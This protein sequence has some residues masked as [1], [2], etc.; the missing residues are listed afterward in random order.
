MNHVIQ[1]LTEHRSYRHYKKDQ[2]SNEQLD[3][4][5]ASAQ[6]APSW[7]HGQQV[8]VIVVQDERKKQRLAEL[9]GN[10][11]Y[12][13]DCP[14]F[15]V[16]CA[17]FYRA[18]LASQIEEIPIEVT[19]DV[20]A[21]LI[22]ATD[23]GIALGNAIAA[24]ESLGLN[25]VPIGGIRRNPLEVIE[26]LEI[27]NYV[28]PIVGL[29]IGYGENDPGLN[30]RLPKETFIHREVYN[31]NQET[32]ILSYNE[33]YQKH[34]SKTSSKPSTTWTSRVTSFYKETHYNNQYPDV[35]TMLKKQGFTCNDMK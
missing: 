7:I 15:L 26:T 24:A 21:L 16:F 25:I 2:L 19:N 20:D 30:P 5:L 17:D 13:K 11:Q 23:V 10:Q 4:I 8:S 27:P 14:T 29:C 31:K 33:E 12:I 18:H 6:A 28:I 1:T 35:P 22:G 3:A 9:S 34:L 32:L